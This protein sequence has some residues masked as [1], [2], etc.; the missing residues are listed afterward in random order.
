M[1]WWAICLACAVFALPLSGWS[2]LFAQSINISPCGRSSEND[3]PENWACLTFDLRADHRARSTR[4]IAVAEPG[5]SDE[6]PELLVY[7]ARI[8]T[9]R[10]ISRTLLE[11]RTFLE[12]ERASPLGDARASVGVRA[13]FETPSRRPGDP[14]S[15]FN[16]TGRRVRLERGSL[17][18]G[19]LAVGY[20]PSAFYFT[21]SL[22]YTTGYATE[23]SSTLASYT[24]RQKD[25]WRITISLEDAKPRH[26]AEDPWGRYRRGVTI[27]PVVAVERK[28]SWGQG[29]VALAAHPIKA[30]SESGCCGKGG[31]AV[32][33]AAM[34]GMEGW[35]DWSL[36]SSE[37]LLNV[38][39]SR[40]A[41]DYLNATNYPA[42][43]AIANDGRLHLTR[44][45]AAVLSLGHY[46]RRSLRNIISLSAVR[47]S[48]ATDQFR[49]S[50]NGKILQAAMEYSFQRGF[51]AGAEL[52]FHEDILRD[53]LHGNSEAI[54][55]RHLTAVAYIRKR[56]RLRL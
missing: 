36:G 9:D 37:F 51:V 18:L 23:Q 43:F 15:T 33:W 11:A 30:A 40:G 32:G 41:L 14:S 38:S 46:W 5:R 6:G 13:Q 3:G 49:L 28:F 50:V 55:A 10:P 2:P 35:F 8:Q 26:L 20:M 54:R 25:G 17:E 12:V 16:R 21:P 31:S 24:F 7:E 29:Q 4:R 22:S 45:S 44:G 48:L 27:D 52:G 39:A 56:I 19:S 42:D 34:A 53:R 1:P 47:T